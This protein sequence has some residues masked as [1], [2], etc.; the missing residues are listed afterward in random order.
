VRRRVRL[1]D[2]GPFMGFAILLLKPLLLLFT[3]RRWSGFEHVPASGGVILAANH[4]S[5]A[6]PIVLADFVLYGLGRPPRFMAKSTLFNGR[7]LVPTVMRGASQIPVHRHTADAS[8]A[9]RDAVAALQAGECVVIYPEGTVSR[10]PGKWPMAARTGVARLALLS[11]APVVPVGQWGAEAILDSYRSKGL[12]LLPPHPVH[13]TAGPPVDLSA[14]RGQE[15]T[16]EVLRG[17]TAAVMADITALVE[18]LREERA[19]E[20]VHVWQRTIDERRTA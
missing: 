2:T 10:D 11:G 13:V 1:R 19:P 4:I 7:G 9:L 20:V 8:A 16:A 18:G 5:H 3:R 6:D 15:L 12:H 17:A 14:Y